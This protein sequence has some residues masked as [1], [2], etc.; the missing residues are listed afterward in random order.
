M[1]DAV[2]GVTEELGD[3]VAETETVGLA[4]RVALTEG[5]SESE[6][7]ALGVSKSDMLNWIGDAIGNCVSVGLVLGA[8]VFEGKTT[9]WTMP[10]VWE[11]LGLAFGNCGIS[12]RAPY[13]GR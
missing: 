7:E 6:G 12:V 3:G 13:S 5:V 10:A 9:H 8:G 1:R 2:S 4:D 11:G